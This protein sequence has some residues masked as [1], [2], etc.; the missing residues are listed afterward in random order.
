MPNKFDKLA[1]QAAEMADEEFKIEFSRLT[2]L[3]D[4]EIKKIIDE[5][6]ISKQDLADVLSKIKDSTT[7]N[8]SKA[9]A[10]Q[11][12]NNG[13]SALVGIVKKLI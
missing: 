8:D 6:G 11:N 12:I 9:K 10:I 3:N 4:D 7:S 2:R 1:K 5:T 13:V